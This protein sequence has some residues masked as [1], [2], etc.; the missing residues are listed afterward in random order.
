M[1]VMSVEPW[2]IRPPLTLFLQQTDTCSNHRYVFQFIPI[3]L[4][5][6]DEIVRPCD[7]HSIETM[8]LRKHLTK[9]KNMRKWMVEIL[10]KF[11]NHAIKSGGHGSILITKI[12]QFTAIYFNFVL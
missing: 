11:E 3:Q 12:Y 8:T 1:L 4:V 7:R 2:V 5:K 6:G 10:R 9:Y